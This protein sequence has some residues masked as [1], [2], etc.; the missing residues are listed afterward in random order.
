MSTKTNLLLKLA[1]LLLFPFSIIYGFILYLRNKLYD[2]NI[3]KS[4][5]FETPIITIGNLSTGGTGK[6]PHIEFLIKNLKDE[7]KLATL[8]RGYKRKTKGFVLADANSTAEDIGDEPKQFKNKFENIPIAVDANRKNGINQLLNQFPDLDLIL[9]DDAFQ[10]RKVKANISILLTEYSNPFYKDYILPM[11]HLREARAGYKRADIIIITKCPDVLSPFDLNR[12]KAEIQLQDHQEIY[13]SYIEYGQLVAVTDG[14]KQIADYNLSDYSIT[15]LSGI[16]NPAALKFYIKRYA[17]EVNEVQFP[18]HHFFTDN[19]LKKIESKFNSFISKQKIIIT[20]EK[21]AVRLDKEKF[22]HL[23]IFY[24]PIE[25][26]FHLEDQK[27]IV[28]QISNY[29]RKN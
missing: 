12:I 1:R 26:K 2:V 29:V 10:H 3:L 15:L 17:K 14:A 13:F 24:I 21:D 22:K 11:G 25:I 9:L 7:F 18:D 5:S 19:D 23:P 20:T 16:A 28:K 27:N 6:S 4:K 8:S